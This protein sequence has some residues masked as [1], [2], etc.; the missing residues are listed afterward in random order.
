[1]AEAQTGSGPIR[2]TDDKVHKL[3][4]KGGVLQYARYW[5]DG[6]RQGHEWVDVPTEPANDFGVE[7]RTK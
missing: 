7:G 1:M 2:T 4:W 5:T 3:R 6:E